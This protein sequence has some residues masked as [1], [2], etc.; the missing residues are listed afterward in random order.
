M[1]DE[2]PADI[3]ALIDTVFTAFNSKN[4]TLLN[5]VYGANVVIV[6]G[7]APYRWSGPQ[8][9]AEWW[10]DAQT[11]AEAGGVESEHFAH[12]GILAWGVSGDR[13]YASISAT[14]TI[15]L[16]NG[17]LIIRPGILTYTFA[18]QSDV[19]RAEGHTWGRLS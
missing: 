15:T 11:W 7:F 8:A 4:A 3:V 19:W 12:K 6:D 9:L 5:S 17:K 10:A 16:G 1:L 2:L 18:R 14:L 13:A